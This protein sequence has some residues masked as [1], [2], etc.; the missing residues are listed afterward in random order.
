MRRARVPVH[1]RLEQSLS[2]PGVP[3]RAWVPSLCMAKCR[4]VFI[5]LLYVSFIVAAPF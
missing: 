1:S 5:C 3:G 2:A 4:T